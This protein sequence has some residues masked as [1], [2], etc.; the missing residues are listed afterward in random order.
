MTSVT[1]LLLSLGCLAL[2]DAGLDNQWQCLETRYT[3]I[4]YKSFGDLHKFN[5]K[6]EYGRAPWKVNQL[7]SSGDSGNLIG[8]IEEK[9][10]KLLERVQGILDMHIL[11][12][13][14]NINLYSNKNELYAAYPMNWGSTSRYYKTSSIPRAWY[15]YERNTIYI[16]T[17]D[18]HDGILAHEVAHAIIDNYLLVRPPK[19]TA[20]ILA[21]YVGSQVRDD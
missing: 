1:I 8:H 11:K 10:D 13:K 15:V 18:L 9:V 3:I 7:F 21:R 12:R 14:I 20:E 2:G 4:R 5:E 16:N 6:I 17:D 19:E